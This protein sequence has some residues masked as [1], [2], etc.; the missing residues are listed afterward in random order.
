[1]LRFDDALGLDLA[2]W[3]PAVVAVPEQVQEWM[4][5]REEA[6]K[7]RRWGDADGLRA[8]VREA[9]YEIEDTGEGAV[10]RAV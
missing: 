5:Q 9:G 10:A 8:L 6:R 1:M 2:N 4:A 7:E 3:Q